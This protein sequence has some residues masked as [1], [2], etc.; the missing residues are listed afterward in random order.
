MTGISNAAAN[1]LGLVG[2]G[3]SGLTVIG[4][5]KSCVTKKLPM[6][7]TDN[8]YVRGSPSVVGRFALTQF[9]P[10]RDREPWVCV[11]QSY[12]GR[13]G[14]VISAPSYWTAN[15]SADGLLSTPL[16]LSLFAIKPAPAKS[17]SADLCLTR[18][19][20]ASA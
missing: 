13:V 2:A 19:V 10:E 4:L 17:T 20:Q 16:C 18:L 8:N 12:V 15:I 5:G 1:D 9:L 3:C 14:T 7:C 11:H 6:C